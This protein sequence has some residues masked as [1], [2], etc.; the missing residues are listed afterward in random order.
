MNWNEEEWSWLIQHTCLNR[1]KQ[2]ILWFLVVIC[3]HPLQNVTILLGIQFEMLCIKLL[4]LIVAS[5]I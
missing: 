5:R 3:I 1:M 2:T 4:A